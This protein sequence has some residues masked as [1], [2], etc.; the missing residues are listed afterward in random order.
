MLAYSLDSYQAH[1]N[2]LRQNFK[3]HYFPG[4]WVVWWVVGWLGGW[5]F[6]WGGIEIKANSAQLKLELGLSLATPWA[7]ACNH[8]CV[9]FNNTGP[10][11]ED[12]VPHSEVLWC[13]PS[14][15]AD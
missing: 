13:K 1:V 11:V 14:I 8:Q 10:K 15:S 3:F 2:L 6:G 4:G 5:V 9:N 7:S 12:L